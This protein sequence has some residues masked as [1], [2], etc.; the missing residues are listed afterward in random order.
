LAVSLFVLLSVAGLTLVQH[1]VAP[2][3]RQEHNDVAGFIYA[4]L[5][6]AYAVLLAF[7]VIAVW[8]QYQAARDTADREASELAEIYWL[9]NQLPESEGRYV[10]ELA[11]SYA[12]V[13]VEEEWPLMEDGQSSPRAWALMDEIRQ[14]IGEFEASTS[15]EQVIYDQGMSRV[16]DLADARTLRLLET[17]EDIPAILWVVLL[18]G[19]V[20]TMGFT[21]LFGLE[22][23]WAH[24][25]MVAALAAVIALV[26]FTI[27]S[28]DNPF[29]GDVRLDPEALELV[30]HRFEENQE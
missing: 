7:V 16:H 13:V 21:Y 29:A 8:E 30:L 27:Y 22:N 9:A 19:G 26:L 4:V 20:I 11:Q 3:L 12:R 10:Q 2:G 24:R 14:R 23:T 5:G 1:L 17:H 25:L 18:T 15:T 28:L 6:I